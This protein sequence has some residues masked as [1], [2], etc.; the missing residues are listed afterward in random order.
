MGRR[1][2]IFLGW[3][4]MGKWHDKNVVDWII[5]LSSVT[6][7]TVQTLRTFACSTVTKS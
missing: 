4:Q 6:S 2:E 5:T 1:G 3:T 7:G